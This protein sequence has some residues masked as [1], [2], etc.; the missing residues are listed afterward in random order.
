MHIGPDVL[1]LVVATAIAAAFGA[2]VTHQHPTI[3][4]P[5]MVAIA[6]VTVIV[7]AAGMAS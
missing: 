1:A 7:T 4:K 3:A 2:Y 5:L 6:I